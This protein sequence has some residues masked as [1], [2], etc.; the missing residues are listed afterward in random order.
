MHQTTCRAALVSPR[1]DIAIVEMSHVF[2][3]SQLPDSRTY[4]S[5]LHIFLFLFIVCYHYYGE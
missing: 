4:L 5:P 3:C 2:I 1:I